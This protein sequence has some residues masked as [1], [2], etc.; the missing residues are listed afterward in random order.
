MIIPF[1][2]AR[3]TS[4]AMDWRLRDCAFGQEPVSRWCETPL[5]ETNLEAQKGQDR[6]VPRWMRE[7]R[8]WIKERLVDAS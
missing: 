2:S 5:A 7:L 1:G 4:L 3:R 8:C 6:S